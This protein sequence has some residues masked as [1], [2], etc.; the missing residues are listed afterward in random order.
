MVGCVDGSVSDCVFNQIDVGVYVVSGEELSV[1]NNRHTG[2]GR[3]FFYQEAIGGSLTNSTIEGN[4]VDGLADPSSG[5]FSGG[6]NVIGVSIGGTSTASG[7]RI[8]NNQFSGIGPSSGGSVN[9]AIMLI[10]TTPTQITD[11]VISGNQISFVNSGSTGQAYGIRIFG[12]SNANQLKRIQVVNN[13]VLSTGLNALSGSG[14]QLKSVIW[15]ACSGNNIV[16]TGQNI[17]SS[18]FAGIDMQDVSDG[19]ILGNTVSIVT[20]AVNPNAAGITLHQ[21]GNN[22]VIGS[23]TVDAASTNIDHINVMQTNADAASIINVEVVN[24]VCG[25]SLS[26]GCVVGIRCN[27]SSTPGSTSWKIANN[28]IRGFNSFGIELLDAAG[29]GVTDFAIS[30][31]DIKGNSAGVIGI[32]VINVNRFRI[33]GNSVYL[34]DATADGKHA[35]DLS[36]SGLGIISGNSFWVDTVAA[37]TAIVNQ[38][39]GT[40]NNL[41]VGNYVECISVATAKAIVVAAASAYA[42]GNYVLNFSIGNQYVGTTNTGNV[43]QNWA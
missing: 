42:D 1:R 36:G 39:G 3:F 38:N 6:G 16:N 34:T 14:I 22:V 13:N 43:G 11:C 18:V 24:N 32:E 10:S 12:S 4:N 35:L 30:G 23:N 31:N 17:A 28:I 15:V 21:Q 37:A 27:P 25:T 9:G 33:Q 40:G 8:V 19:T 41:Y 5:P 7:I 26:P 20:S 2:G 29:V